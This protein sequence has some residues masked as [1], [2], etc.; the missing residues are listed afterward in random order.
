MNCRGLPIAFVLF[1]AL[2]GAAQTN[3]TAPSRR[4]N[5]TTLATRDASASL[6]AEQVRAACV[7]GRRCICGRILKVLPDGLVVESGYSSLL[8]SPIDQSWL[9][10]GTVPASRDS[11][12]VE[13]REPDSICAGLVF[14]TDVPR[15]NGVKAKAYDYVVLHAYPAGRYTYAS[16]GS[17]QRTVRRFSCGLETAV[18]LSIDADEKTKAGPA[19]VVT[20]ASH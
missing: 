16:A 15:T 13:A 6:R 20:S 9:V 5:E 10:P 7:Q 17:I 11:H 19:A 18:Q 2:S 3:A 12:L 4:T 8:R 1:A 14:L